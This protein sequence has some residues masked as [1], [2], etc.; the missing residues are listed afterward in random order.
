MSDYYRADKVSIKA[1]TQP[2]EV[3][4]DLLDKNLMVFKS[5]NVTKVLIIFYK[6]MFY[7]KKVRKYP[8]FFLFCSFCLF[9]TKDNK[10]S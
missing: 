5:E 7:I 9:Y 4:S 10:P 3:L 1:F 6:L 8:N 2:N